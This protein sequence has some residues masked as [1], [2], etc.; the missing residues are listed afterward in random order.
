MSGNG[1][2]DG[3]G[4]DEGDDGVEGGDNGDVSDIVTSIGGFWESPTPIWSLNPFLL[5]LCCKSDLSHKKSC[6]YGWSASCFCFCNHSC[7]SHLDAHWNLAHCTSH[8]DAHYTFAG[9][10]DSQGHHTCSILWNCPWRGGE[11]AGEL[12]EDNLTGG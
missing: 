11:W 7:S 3:A 8:L 10:C 4:D 9:I 6:T 5:T 12:F 2:S 1:D